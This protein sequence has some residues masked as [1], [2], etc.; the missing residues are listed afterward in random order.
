MVAHLSA[1]GRYRVLRKL[2]PR[3]VVAFPRPEFSL[4]GVILDTETTVSIIASRT[5]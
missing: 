2:E 1:S 4:K 3:E 5:S